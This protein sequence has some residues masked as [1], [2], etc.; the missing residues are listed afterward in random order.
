MF[1]LHVVLFDR[2]ASIILNDE[3]YTGDALQTPYRNTGQGSPPPNLVSAD[4]KCIEI[5]PLIV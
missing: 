5:K 2:F 4:N 1:I 3:I